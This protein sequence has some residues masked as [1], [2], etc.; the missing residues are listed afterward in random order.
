MRMEIRS[1]SIK[2]RGEDDAGHDKGALRRNRGTRDDEV[3][4][5]HHQCQAG[6]DFLYRIAQRYPRDQRQ[7]TTHEDKDEAADETEMQPGDHQQMGQTGVAKRLLVRLGNGT[8]LSGDQGGCDPAGRTG[9][10]RRD[11]PRH[12][13]AKPLHEFLPAAA[14]G[15][16]AFVLAA[17]ET[18]CA[19]E[20][21]ADTADLGEVELAL[22]IAPARQDLQRHR[23]DHGF[24][25]DPVARV[26][27]VARLRDMQAQAP[28]LIAG[29]EAGQRLRLDDDAPAP[30][31]QVDIDDPAGDGDRSELPLQHRRLPLPG[32]SAHQRKAGGKD[33]SARVPPG[34]TPDA[35]ASPSSQQRRRSPP[36]GR[37][38]AGARPSARNRPRSRRQ[39]TPATTASAGRARRPG[40]RRARRRGVPHHAGT[41]PSRRS[42]IAASAIV[43][44]PLSENETSGVQS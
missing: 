41:R 37:A 7:S 1:R 25:A 34:T 12:F 21:I 38:T 22:E 28:R 40:A 6:G 35:D 5:Q 10:H 27:L 13:R 9:K 26:E 39:R 29:I 43:A 30:L 33:A 24:E 19:A 17:G 15:R 23:M 32:A 18:T 44:P 36:P 42:A 20:G 3:A 8:A 14:V 31:G 11:A 2:H 4:S 16:G